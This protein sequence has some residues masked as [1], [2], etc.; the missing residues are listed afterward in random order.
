MKRKLLLSGITIKAKG[1]I[2]MVILLLAILF[3][4]GYEGMAA[5]VTLT[6]V[7][8]SSVNGHLFACPT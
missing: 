3:S 5:P 2:P 1:I 8:T 7:H 4:L 6:I